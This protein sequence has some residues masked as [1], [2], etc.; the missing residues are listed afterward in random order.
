MSDGTIKI[1]IEV[2]DKGVETQTKAAAKKAG[3]SAGDELESGLA[4]GAKEGA[5]KAE[6][7]ISGIDPGDVD[8]N[9]TADASK[10]ESEVRSVGDAGSSAGKEAGDGLESGLEQGAQAGSSG[11][12]SIIGGLGETLKGGLVAA[13]A[14][15]GIDALVGTMQEAIEVAN[16]YGE[17][18]GKLSTAAQTTGVSTENMNS[19][20]RDMVGIL[21]E[22]DQ[23]VEAVNHLFQL[24]GDNTQQL[25]SWTNA[26][27][28]IYATFGDS[29]P[30]EGLT[31]AA[32]ETAKC[33]T[34]TGP[35]ADA[36][37]W[38]SKEA[39]A[40]GVALSGNSAAIQAFTAGVE[41]GMSSEDAFNAALAACS[42]EQERAA[43]IT[44]TMTGAYSEAGDTYSKTNSD[45]IEYRKSQDA[46]T[47]SQAELGEALMPVQTAF[48]DFSAWLT[49]EGAGAVTTAIGWLE[50]FGAKAAEYLQPF[51]D[52]VL[53]ALQAA[54]DQL[55][56]SVAPKI[57]DM[58][59]KV[60]QFFEENQP[61]FDALA[62]FLGAVLPI[63]LQVVITYINLLWNSISTAGQVIMD[64]WN[65]I[66]PVVVPLIEQITDALK[67]DILPAIEDLSKK[68]EEF[69]TTVLTV[70]QIVVGT[71]AGFVANIIKFFTQDVPNA[72]TSMGQFFGRLPSMIGGALGGA[73]SSVGQFVGQLAQKG[74]AAASTFA[75]NITQGIR[76]IN[77]WSAGANI[78]TGLWN[79]IVQGGSWIFGQISR[80]AWD[81]V[82][83]AK[84]AL[85]IHSPSRVFRDQVGK[86]I[87][88]G[89]E[90]GYRQNDPAV[91][92]AQSLQAGV[93]RVQ[94]SASSAMNFE[95]FGEIR[96]TINFNQPVQ[97]PDQLAK[98]MKLYSH[99]GLAASN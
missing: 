44:A 26:C 45:L 68:L 99:Y 83:T 90:L 47:A 78:V 65:T 77:L 98:T 8:V 81:I 62:E 37:N 23:S 1:G 80:W 17:D 13:G 86:N 21:G 29:L 96:Q 30:L 97:T 75:S 56:E 41:S 28:G 32:N 25:S 9:V 43:L 72:I 12:E 27:A 22:T 15:L 70:V 92:I 49:G 4:E 59:A 61:T 93:S 71:V 2:E 76:G 57:E 5:A 38:V 89:V 95:S 87:A 84:A 35:F 54:W 74:A 11:A 48:N 34:V 94:A 40:N 64:V 31:E 14:A 42:S 16:E 91:G 58:G 85:G 53:P 51:V 73:I 36:L 79:G 63:V 66:S 60:S 20:Y 55:Y 19:T 46:L 39:V 67:N 33:G 7:E 88:A 6:S 18:M 69:Q 50:S 24:C 52:A 3:A 10:A 82:D